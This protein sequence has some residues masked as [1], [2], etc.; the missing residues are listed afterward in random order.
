MLDTF[1]DI[2][3][4]FE[5]MCFNSVYLLRLLLDEGRE[6]VRQ[7]QNLLA[8]LVNFDARVAFFDGILH[9]FVALRFRAQDHLLHHLSPVRLQHL[10][11]VFVRFTAVDEPEYSFHLLLQSGLRPHGCL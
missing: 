8:G 7:L 4:R 1:L 2:A 11:Q 5:N 9:D 6:V 3:S 10:V